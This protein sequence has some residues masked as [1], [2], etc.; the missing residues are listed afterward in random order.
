MAIREI[1]DPHLRKAGRALLPIVSAVRDCQLQQ[2]N[3]VYSQVFKEA[4]EELLGEAIGALELVDQQALIATDRTAF[5]AV[6]QSVHVIERA[7]AA[8]KVE[9]KL[10]EFRVRSQ[11]QE[12]NDLVESTTGGPTNFP[13]SSGSKGPQKTTYQNFL[14]AAAY[15]L[16]HSKS[17]DR[18]TLR[19]DAIAHLE[20][21]PTSKAFKQLIDN[22]GRHD[23]VNR[24]PVMV[25]QARVK[26]LISRCGY[27]RLQHFIH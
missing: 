20:G 21:V 17:T 13:H 23:G 1:Q 6:W 22:L 25:H 18:K 16:Y 19:L 14:R 12:F 2:P 9:G 4:A 7:L 3:F 8:D 26:K 15:E 27:T 5:S 24:H 11:L 10:A